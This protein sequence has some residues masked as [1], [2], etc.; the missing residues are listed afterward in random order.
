MKK[1]LAALVQSEASK[2]T[3]TPTPK[4]PEP[5]EPV[6]SELPKNQTLVRKETRLREDQLS[7]LTTLTRRLNRAREGGERLTENTLIRIAIDL[8]M[9]RADELAGN[10]EDELGE[11]V[12]HE[13]G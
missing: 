12:Y 11:S 10:T 6:T 1:R 2:P 13:K 9:S 5:T 7:D 8:L 3:A 4:P